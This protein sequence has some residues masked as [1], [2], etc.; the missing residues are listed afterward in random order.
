MQTFLRG[1]HVVDYDREALA[2]A[3][4]AAT[5]LAEAEGLPAHGRAIDL[6]FETEG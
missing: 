5:V 1:I 2:G 3:R 6:R 4:R